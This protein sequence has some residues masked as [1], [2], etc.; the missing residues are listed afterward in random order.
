LDSHTTGKS[1]D[2]KCG[3]TPVKKARTVHVSAGAVKLA[4]KYAGDVKFC[5]EEAGRADPA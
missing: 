5:A 3:R 2:K 4:G 1:R